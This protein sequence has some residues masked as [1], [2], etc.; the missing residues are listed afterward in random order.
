MNIVAMIAAF[1]VIAA[2]LYV[3]MN[4]VITR[5]DARYERRSTKF[6]RKDPG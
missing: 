1:V 5:M 6:R 4:L 2:C 3:F